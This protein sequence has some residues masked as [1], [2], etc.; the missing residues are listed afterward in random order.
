MPRSITSIALAAALA[1]W[2]LVPMTSAS[3]ADISFLSGQNSGEWLA[4]RL[5]GS[6]VL[7]SKGEII[8]RV[9]DVVQDANGQTQAVVVGVGGFLGVG[10]K[11]VGVPF[12]S[13]RVGDVVSG[14]RL[15]VLD[16]T[17]AQLQAAP[18]YKTTDPTRTERAKQKVAD[19]A[20]IAKDK[21]I[22]LGKR[23]SEAVGGAKDGTNAPSGGLQAPPAKK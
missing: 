11:R 18:I 16:V 22:E 6:T 3:A 5:G 2:T 9:E 12:K 10:T 4:V 14:R 19:W 20:R 13:I 17:K 1:G 23:A 8:G 21:A 15:V 7:N